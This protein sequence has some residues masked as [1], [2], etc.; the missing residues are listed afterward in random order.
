MGLRRPVDL[1]Q[2]IEWGTENV[3][4]ITMIRAK[5]YGMNIHQLEPLT[6]ID[7][8]DDLRELM[9]GYFIMV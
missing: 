8:A 5:E 9:P 6:D 7:T 2:G 1:F 4:R 3:L